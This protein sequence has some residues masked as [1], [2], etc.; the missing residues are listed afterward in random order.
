M[1]IFLLQIGT[2]DPLYPDSVNLHNRL[3]R[4]GIDSEL[5]I[6]PNASH[7]FDRCLKKDGTHKEQWETMWYAYERIVKRL[8]DVYGWS[9]FGC[10][11]SSKVVLEEKI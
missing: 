1:M 8:R 9:G 2:S 11:C 6:V 10:G 7:A 4:S 3:V 5:I